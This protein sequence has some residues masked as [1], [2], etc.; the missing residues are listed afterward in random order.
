[1]AIAA[2]NDSYPKIIWI[3]GGGFSNFLDVYGNIGGEPEA[4]AIAVVALGALDAA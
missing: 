2:V 3:P 1:V 4:Q